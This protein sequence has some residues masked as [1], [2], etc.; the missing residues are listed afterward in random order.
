MRVSGA[1]AYRYSTAMLT[2]ATCNR[3]SKVG[4]CNFTDIVRSQFHGFAG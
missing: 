2:F 3:V 1:G 4:F